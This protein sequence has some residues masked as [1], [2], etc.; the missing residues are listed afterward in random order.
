MVREKRLCRKK[1][2]ECFIRKQSPARSEADAIAILLNQAI[3]DLPSNSR[4]HLLKSLLSEGSG[5]LSQIHAAVQAQ[6]EKKAL[7]ESCVL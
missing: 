5:Q 7:F 1:R 3:G 6:S 4:S 2:L